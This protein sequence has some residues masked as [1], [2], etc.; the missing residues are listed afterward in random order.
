[1]RPEEEEVF[2]QNNF[3]RIRY[4]KSIEKAGKGAAMDQ[5]R[6]GV[7]TLIEY[8]MRSGDIDDRYRSNQRMQE[9]IRAHRRIQDQ[10]GKGYSKEVIFRDRTTLEGIEFDVDGR[11]DGVFEG[12]DE[13]GKDKV[14]IDE[15][16]STT[17]PLDSLDGEANPLHWAQAKCYA[18]FYC[19]QRDRASI[20]VRLTYVNLDED[21]LY[22]TFTKTFQREELEAFYLDL[23]GRYLE[24]SRLLVAWK[25]KRDGSLADFPFPYEDFRPG[26]RTMAVGVYQTIEEGGALFVEA[27]TGIGKTISALYP[28]LLAM[29]RL[30]VKKIFYLTARTTTQREPARAMD[31][32]RDQ[33]LC[34][35]QVTLTAKSKICLNEKLVCDPNHCPYAKGHFDR[36]NAAILDLFQAEDGMDWATITEYAEKHRV[37]PHEFQLDMTDFADLVL[38]DY[39]YFFD[40]RVYL[41]RAF[42]SDDPTTVVLVDEAHNLVDRGR[43]MYSAEISR[44]TLRR[45]AALFR[46]KA[47]KNKDKKSKAVDRAIARKADRAGR[48]MEDFHQALGQ[49]DQV[50]TAENPEDF[51]LALKGLAQAMDPYLA[52]EGDDPDYEEVRQAYFD[53]TAYTKIDDCRMEGFLNLLTL[54]QGDLYWKIR[55]IDPTDLLQ[56]TIRRVKAAIF[57]SATL[58]PMAFYARLL[59]GGESPRVLHLDSPFPPDHLDLAQVSLSTRYKDRDRTMEDL[60]GLLHHFLEG[61]EAGGNAMVFFP[62]YA[63]LNQV[64]RAY[65]DRFGEEVLVQDPEASHKDREAVLARYM[66][67]EDLAGFFVLGGLFAEG[68]DLPG[69][70]L[71][72]VAVVSVGLPG[73]SFEQDVIKDYFNGEGLSGFDYAYTFPG[74]NRVLQAAGR[75]IR[76]ETDRGRVL[77]VD[78][79]FAQ[80]RYRALY[81]RHWK[82]MRYFLS[83][84]DY[85]NEERKDR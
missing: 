11:A 31:R 60:T 65:R 66:E 15:I 69:L 26:Q 39:N 12:K 36:V 77:L 38:C 43:E 14:L 19:K 20:E 35:K 79:R 41:R 16:K 34:I 25:K 6:M 28:A 74:M 45:L 27:P 83:V 4:N 53:I 9:G 42:D 61:E 78:D 63:Y 81:P 22:R 64:A 40:P 46:D 30:G 52:K 32:M 82:G 58:S 7:R 62:S 72:R 75:L 70:A 85:M 13:D 3:P 23:L 33:G 50:A 57:F 51:Y 10:Y 29:P 56:A 54:R 44:E 17:R 71:T 5:I 47:K 8:V 49:P 80:A 18:H 55:C 67:E 48:V 21:L 37:C 2:P 84:E 1:M 59:G 68:I 24:F 73:L 76:T